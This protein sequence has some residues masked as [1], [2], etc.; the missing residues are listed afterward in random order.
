MLLA[1]GVA[2]SFALVAG[3]LQGC[4]AAVG[5]GAV[6]GTNTYVDRRSSGTMLDD[7]LI[8]FRVLEAIGAV[9]ELQEVVHIN[10]TSINGVVL[11]TGETPTEAM[12]AQVAE[13]ARSVAN[14]REVY[15]E[16]IVSAQTSMLSRSN[17]SILSAKVKTGLISNNF[18]EGSRIKVV[19]EQATVYLMGVVTRAEGDMATQIARNVGGVQRVVKIFEYID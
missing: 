9:P 5:A 3:Q 14:V 18:A 8:E 2:L 19:T 7:E 16:V 15:N 6:T 10:A 1:I 11:V 17:D 12:R 4:A 13:L